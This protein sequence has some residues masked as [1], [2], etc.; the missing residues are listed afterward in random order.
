MTTKEYNLTIEQDVTEYMAQ[1]RSEDDWNARC[2]AV[3][4]ANNGYP[5]F[6]FVAIVL[7]GLAGKTAANFGGSAELNIR[8]IK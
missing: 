2:E 7:S 4:E 3:K 6:W 8:S 5:A 1:A